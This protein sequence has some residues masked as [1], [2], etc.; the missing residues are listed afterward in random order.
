LERSYAAD[1]LSCQLLCMYRSRCE[2]YS[3]EEST[4]TSA[5]NCVFYSTYIDGSKVVSS[6]SGIYFSD[7]YPDDGSNFCYGSTEL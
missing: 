4:S 2:A 3:F 7:K 5:K 1:P 6:S